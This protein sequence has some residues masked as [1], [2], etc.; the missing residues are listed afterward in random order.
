VYIDKTF[1]RLQAL[2]HDETWH[3]LFDAET[4]TFNGKA[5]RG[6]KLI[7]G[8][9]K[10]V[11]RKLVHN[12]PVSVVHGDYCFSNIL[13]DIGNQIVRLIDPRGSFG[14][15]GI[16]GDSRYDIAKLRHSICEG[17]DYIVADMFDLQESGTQYES[18]IYHS[19]LPQVLGVLFDKAVGEMGYALNE[20][21]F[22]EG[23]LFLSMLPL[24]SDQPRRQK[25]M[26]LT[27]LSLLN[28]VL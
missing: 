22:I 17:Y 16:Y 9:V 8:D 25:M 5:L 15:K 24:H 11:T 23:L 4:I 19:G 7:Q 18:C 28:E 27:G 14:V 3:T 20:I 10:A 21:R 2:M 6:W 26:L 1:E 13:Y 12:A